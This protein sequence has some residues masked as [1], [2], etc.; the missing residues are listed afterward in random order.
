MT[1]TSDVLARRCGAIYARSVGKLRRRATSV[2]GVVVGAVAL[3]LFA[4]LWVPLTAAADVARGRRRCPTTR[5]LAFGWGWCW[6]E[7]G[8]VGAAAALWAR[9]RAGDRHAHYELQRWWAAHLM[10]LLRRTTGLTV[11]VEGVEALSAG[12]AVVL[13]RH[14]SLADSLVSAWVITSLAGTRPRYVLKRE[15][16]ADPCLDVVG[17]RLPNHFLDRDA[18]DSAAELAALRDLA[19]GMGDDDVAVIFPEG[20]RASPSK[21]ARALARLAE[22]DPVR[23][24]RLASLQHLLPPRPAGTAALLEGAPDADVVVAW[25]IGFEGLDTFAGILRALGRRAPRIRFVATRVPRHEVPA[26]PDE[27]TSWLDGWW[28]AVD[29]AVDRALVEHSDHRPVP[30]TARAVDA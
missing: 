2:T 26:D 28:L 12:R 4:P 20:T 10:D 29:G 7:L 18:A 9:G 3:T 27:L 14:C 30:S 13:C 23:A 15:L 8:G 11:D 17:G 21:R 24:D 16:L 6:L 22:R 19:A 5:L 25:H 1:A